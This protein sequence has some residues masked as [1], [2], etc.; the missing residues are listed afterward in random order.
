MIAAL[1][2]LAGVAIIVAAWAISRLVRARRLGREGFG[3][4]SEDR[5][6]RHDPRFTEEWVKQL[7]TDATP[8]EPGDP[9]AAPDT[10][11]PE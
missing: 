6:L 10:T 5:R 8:R 3:I 9:P 2:I 1:T 7:R 4:D 11:G